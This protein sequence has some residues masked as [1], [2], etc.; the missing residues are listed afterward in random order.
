MSGHSGRALRPRKSRAGPAMNTLRRIVMLGMGVLA[1]SA[2]QIS[3]VAQGHA[4]AAAAP[5][6]LLSGQSRPTPALDGGTYIH[7]PSTIVRCDGKFYTF[8]TG[9]GGLISDHYEA[10]LGRGGRS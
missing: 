6:V 5:A 9:G 1:L 3:P 8:G 4:A 7:D 10:D 2:F